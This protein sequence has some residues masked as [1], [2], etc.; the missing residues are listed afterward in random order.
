MTKVSQI[1][2]QLCPLVYSGLLHDCEIFANLRL[3]LYQGG[4]RAPDF[5]PSM[6]KEGEGVQ[7]GAAAPGNVLTG[8]RH[9]LG[10]LWR[11]AV[12]QG[13]SKVEKRILS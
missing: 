3:K 13:I 6:C 5:Q 11:P 12:S 2:S 10:G 7:Q 9:L 4:P 1:F 8:E